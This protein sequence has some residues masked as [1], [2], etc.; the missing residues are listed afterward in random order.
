LTVHQLRDDQKHNIPTLQCLGKKKWATTLYT[1]MQSKK[2]DE[3]LYRII[4]FDPVQLP[5]SRN[6]RV[7]RGQQKYQLLN[8]D[9]N[10][11]ATQ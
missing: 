5:E 4:P 6:E 3:T 10:H 8:Q 9:S 11:N 1:A 7:E 2:E